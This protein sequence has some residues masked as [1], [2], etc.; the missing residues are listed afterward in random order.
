LSS[1]QDL[2]LQSLAVSIA[3]SEA[4]SVAVFAG[5]FAVQVQQ[6]LSQMA[7][8]VTH[9]LSVT[10]RS[11]LPSPPMP[12]RRSALTCCVGV[13]SAACVAIAFRSYVYADSTAQYRIRCLLFRPSSSSF[14]QSI[15]VLTEANYSRRDGRTGGRDGTDDQ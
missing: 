7:R 14:F 3:F 8:S 5:V 4:W 2:R 10:L 13:V 6:L 1:T 9:A 11:V 12:H 15:A